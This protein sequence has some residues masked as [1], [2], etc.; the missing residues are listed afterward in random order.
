MD[1]E[2]TNQ[3]FKIVLTFLGRFSRFWHAL[4]P[5]DLLFWSRRHGY[6]SFDDREARVVRMSLTLALWMANSLLLGGTYAVRLIRLSSQIVSSSW[7]SHWRLFFRRLAWIISYNLLNW[8]LLL[9]LSLFGLT[10][11]CS[12]SG[13]FWLGLSRILWLALFFRFIRCLGT[14]RLLLLIS[15][16]LINFGTIDLRMLDLRLTRLLHGVD[17]LTQKA[18]HALEMRLTVFLHPLGELADLLEG[19]L[20]LLV[21][22]ILLRL[23]ISFD[24]WNYFPGLI[25]D[26]RLRMLAGTPIFLSAHSEAALLSIEVRITHFSTM[27]V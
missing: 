18:S 26:L 10:C 24:L 3:K 17:I 9:R 19:S 21:F 7:S 4:L 11:P 6:R 12:A 8:Q 14:F 13:G 1:F 25:V 16:I 15:F 23:L 5:N 22:F 20:L 27:S 2:S